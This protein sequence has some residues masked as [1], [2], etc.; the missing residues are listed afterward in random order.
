LLAHLRI[1][2]LSL[3][4]LDDAGAAALLASPVVERLAKLDMHHYC[5][6]EMVKRLQS[7]GIEVDASEPQED[8][9]YDGERY[10]YVAVAE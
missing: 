3:G 2:D 4:T 6:P 7:L 9:E 5:S 8:D 10:R 1:L